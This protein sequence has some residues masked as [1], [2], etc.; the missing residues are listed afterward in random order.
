MAFT[1]L[2]NLKYVYNVL[3]VYIVTLVVLHVA[4]IRQTSKLR[5]TIYPRHEC[6]HKCK[7]EI[8]DVARSRGWLCLNS[9]YSAIE[10]RTESCPCY[11]AP[12]TAHLILLVLLPK[13]NY[14]IAEVGQDLKKNGK[15]SRSM[16]INPTILDGR[17]K[18]W[19]DSA[20]PSRSKWRLAI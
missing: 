13:L 12:E 2:Q 20:L 8:R 17:Q 19:C 9:T 6:M 1:M 11:I 16:L 3:F 5:S 18:C 7:G 14:L 4:F 15:K 10:P